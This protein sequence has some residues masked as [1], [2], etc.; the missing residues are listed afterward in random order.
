MEAFDLEYLNRIVDVKDTVHK[1]PFLLHL[2]ELVVDRF[3]TSTDLYSE[4]PH[5]HRVAKVTT[6]S[7]CTMHTYMRVIMQLELAG[8]YWQVLLHVAGL[9]AI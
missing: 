2:V 1:A 8:S 6:E 4:L 7:P 5:V 3:P 9:V